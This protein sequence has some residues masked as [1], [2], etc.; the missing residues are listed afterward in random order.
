M[1]KSVLVFLLVTSGWSDAADRICTAEFAVFRNVSMRMAW[2]MEQSIQLECH[3][4]Q[5]LGRESVLSVLSER[6]VSLS[7]RNLMV[8]F[9]F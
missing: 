9:G 4:Q 6:E 7:A 8:I 5:L 1:Q 2:L 3:S